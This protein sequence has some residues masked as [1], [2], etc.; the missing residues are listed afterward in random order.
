MASRPSPRW[1]FIVRRDRAKLYANLRE[2]FE[3]VPAVQVILDRREG[4]G[5][6]AGDPARRDRRAPLSLLE[7]EQWLTLGFRLIYQGEDL[8]VYEAPAWA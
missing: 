3:G 1:L 8:Q 2:S 7:Q 4:N 6:P 5:A